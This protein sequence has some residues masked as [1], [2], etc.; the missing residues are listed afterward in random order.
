MTE[1][2]EIEWLDSAGRDGWVDKDQGDDLL[3]C[4]CVTVGYLIKV[5]ERGIV[6][7]QGMNEDCYLRPIGIFRSAIT[8]ARKL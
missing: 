1:I 5:D 6:I 2:W 4:P 3:Y 7:A 8:K